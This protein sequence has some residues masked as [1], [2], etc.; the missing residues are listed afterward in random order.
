MEQLRPL[1][2]DTVLL[3]IDMQRMFAEDTECTR[4]IWIG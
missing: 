1:G 2:P 4:R 3:V